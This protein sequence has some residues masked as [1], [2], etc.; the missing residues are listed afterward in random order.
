[1]AKLD[2]LCQQA[3]IGD[4]I[5]PPPSNN[6]TITRTILTRIEAYP[7]QWNGGFV[8]RPAPQWLTLLKE[9][10]Y[11]RSEAMYTIARER[12]VSQLRPAVGTHR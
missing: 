6:A 5:A 9:I 2:P 8:K 12:P 3:R 1:M 7:V 10:L 11:G 4:K